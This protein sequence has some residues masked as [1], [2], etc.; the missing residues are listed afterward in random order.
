MKIT[1]V[2]MA[3]LAL[4]GAVRADGIP[5]IEGTNV[6]GIAAVPAAPG[7]NSVIT[8]PF[9]ALMG[10]GSSG[11]LADMVSTNGMISHAS[12]PAQADQL[13]ILTTDGDDQV[14][15]YYWHKAGDGWTPIT[16]AVLMPDG[17]SRA[18]TPPAADA[19]AIGRGKGL[20]VKR[21]AGGAANVILKGQ[22]TEAKQ[23]T[24]VSEGFNL[25][26]YG[27]VETFNLNNL[28]WT[29]A[30]GVSGTSGDR[31]LV[32]DGSGSFKTYFYYCKD[33]VSG[34][35]QQ[36]QNKWVESTGTG[37]QLASPIAAGQGFWYQ[38]R[39]AGSFTF[40]PDGQ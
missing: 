19:F 28:D 13:V 35:Y 5:P 17:Q 1:V 40:R 11:S 31:I 32:D 2:V 39:G 6:A 24:E 10:A 25:L 38:R 33:G 36:F 27:A 7:G 14:Y 30:Y 8:V 18:L 21:V 22:V 12:D 34:Y 3:L 37:P 16:T 9:E 29:G 15:Y 20:W 4:A 26:G 23:A